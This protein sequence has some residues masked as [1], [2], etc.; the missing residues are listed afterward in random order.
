M[1]NPKWEFI[2]THTARRT[3]VT[4]SL[5]KGMRPEVLMTITGH[6]DNKTMKKY[7][8]IVSKVKEREM[9]NIWRRETLLKV[10]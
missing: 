3:F 1:N 5:E 8:K 2:S 9:N 7:L 4:L 10:V 6:K